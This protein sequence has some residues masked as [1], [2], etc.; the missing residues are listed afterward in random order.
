MSICN[1][2]QA[3]SRC[4]GTTTPIAIFQLGVMFNV[5][6]YDT[7]QTRRDIETNKTNLIHIH[8]VNGDMRI[9]EKVL[10]KEEA[11]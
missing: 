8:Q 7:I 2:S 10:S 9:L 5:M 6:F 3:L 4:K 1:K 11:F